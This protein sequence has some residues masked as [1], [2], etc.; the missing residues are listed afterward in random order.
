MRRLAFWSSLSVLM[1][2]AAA[3]PACAQQ[4]NFDSV[5]ADCGG[6]IPARVVDSCLERVRVLDETNPS[7][8][9]QSLEAQLSRRAENIRLRRD[10]GGPQSY[11]NGP[12]PPGYDQSSQAPPPGYGPGDQ[13]PPTGSDDQPPSPDNN[14]GEPPP[15]PGYDRD[16]GVS[17]DEQPPPNDQNGADDQPPPDDNTGPDDQPPH[18]ESTGPGDDGG[19]P[20]DVDNGHESDGP[21]ADLPPPPDDTSPHP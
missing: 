3:L 21:P 5:M 2:S 7:P 20:P 19:P 13:Q 14:A 15:P 17:P 9:L 10:D 12:P 11:G 8:Q 6:R 1:V 18:D 4:D 16:Q